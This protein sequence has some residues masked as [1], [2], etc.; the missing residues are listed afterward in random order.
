[1]GFSLVAVS[2]VYSPVGMCGPLMVTSLIVGLAAPWHVVPSWIRDQI[3]VSCNG[4]WT[5][6]H[7]ITI[8]VL[9]SYF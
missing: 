2:G 1:M 8:K 9:V 4:R 3:H 6:Y 7:R 5:L